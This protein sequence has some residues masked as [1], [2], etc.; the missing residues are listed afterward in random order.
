MSI[1]QTHPPIDIRKPTGRLAC[2]GLIG[3]FFDQNR[4]VVLFIYQ[5]GN[6]ARITRMEK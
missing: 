2:P 3:P 4:T 5:P 6:L 1:L